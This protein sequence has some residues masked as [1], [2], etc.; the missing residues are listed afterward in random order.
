RR[1]TMVAVVQVPSV[2]P[3]ITEVPL[4]P[5][6]T[7]SD[8]R[9]A[10]APPATPRF[11]YMLLEDLINMHAGELFPGFRVLGCSPFRVARNFDLSID[12]GEVDDL[13]E[14]LQKELRRRERGSAVRLEI[15]HD[16]PIE[17]VVFLRSALRLESDAVYIFESPLHPAD[18]E[19]LGA[20]DEMRESLAEASSPQIVPT[21]K[22]YVEPFRV[23]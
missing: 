10:A 12:E 19:R 15:A 16:T 3:R 17:V 14:T 5:G 2:L 23:I 22:E 20:T 18:P 4:P 7:P 6:A 9:K 8:G 1:E 21:L 11:A 13:L